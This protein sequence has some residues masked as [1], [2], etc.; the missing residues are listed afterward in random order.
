[1]D[2]GDVQNISSTRKPI[3]LVMWD[4]FSQKFQLDLIIYL[5]LRIS[6]L[7]RG[8]TILSRG[9]CELSEGGGGTL[10]LTSRGTAAFLR[11]HWVWGRTEGGGQ[12]IKD[13]ISTGHSLQL[14]LYT[15][16]SANVISYPHSYTSYNERVTF[17]AYH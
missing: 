2:S 5:H 6:Y 10:S 8:T 15:K 1:M 7:L 4:C 14:N 16:L 9:H 12:W 3:S 17:F 13:K 11:G